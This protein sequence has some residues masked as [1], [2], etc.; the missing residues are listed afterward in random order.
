M[1]SSQESLFGRTFLESSAPLITH[2]AVFSERWW[3]RIPPSFH[4]TDAA[5]RTRVWLMDRRDWSHG[6][7][8]MPNTSA[9]PNGASVCSLSQVL[10]T[11]HIPQKYYLSAKAC[12]G[13]LRR[14][15]KRGKELPKSLESALRQVATER[16]EKV[17]GHSEKQAETSGGGSECLVAV[18]DI[19]MCLNAGANNR[20]DGESETFAPVLSPTLLGKESFSPTKSSSVQMVDFCIAHTLTANGFDAS[21]DGT[22]R[23]TPLVPV[24]AHDVAPC[25]TGNYAKQLDN[26][27]TSAGPNVVSCKDHGADA[28]EISPTLRS[29]GHDGSHA[30][31][32]GQVAVAYEED[33][34]YADAYEADSSSVL[35]T[36]RETVGAEAV[37]EWGSRILNPLQSAEVLQSWL[38]GESLRRSSDS[39]R[40]WVDDRPLPC[41]EGSANSTL[42]QV[43]ESG[44]DGRTPQGRGLAKQLSYELGEALPKLPHQDTFQEATLLRLREGAEGARLLRE[45]LSAIQK[46][47]RSADVQAQPTHT[48][49]AVRRLTPEEAEALQGFPRGYTDVPYRGKPAA[50]GPRYKALGNSMAVSVMRWLLQRV[51]EAHNANKAD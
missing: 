30:N 49:L 28:G 3:E 31:G 39:F 16:I 20:I 22:G 15:E 14:A 26:S 51:I 7:S 35:S 47:R 34:R 11:G 10:E 45:T 48:T 32:G 43:W 19:A 8:L 27:D 4:R 33:L 24:F 42:R 40:R 46:V 29:M 1:H 5:G 6:V 36:L 44:P 12:R 50:D 25:L 9:W 13:I 41:A 37:A 18:P 21:E 2:S 17:Q 38:H 23:G